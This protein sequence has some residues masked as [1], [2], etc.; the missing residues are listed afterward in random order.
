MLRS[1]RPRRDSADARPPEPAASESSRAESS[2]PPKPH[3][4]GATARRYL[5]FVARAAEGSP[6]SF[7][8]SLFLFLGGMIFIIYYAHEGYLPELDFG[9]ATSLLIAAALT[10]CLYVVVITA[11]LMMPALFWLLYVRQNGYF[12]VLWDDGADPSRQSAKW[13]VMAFVPPHLGL[14]YFTYS[15]L[16]DLWF[17]P[18]I[19]ALIA[20]WSLAV[21]CFRVRR[22][23]AR[24]PG[25]LKTFA[26]MS[27]GSFCWLGF[28]FAW[29]FALRVGVTQWAEIG[30][31]FATLLT[32]GLL[33]I[34]GSLNVVAIIVPE[35]TSPFLWVGGIAAVIL[36]VTVL[37]FDLSSNMSAFV[38]RKYGWGNI[39]SA[40]LVL[41][42]EG[43]STTEYLGLKPIRLNGDGACRLDG[44]RIVSRLGANYYLEAETPKSRKFKF[45]LP[46]AN[47]VAYEPSA[48][49]STLP[50]PTPSPSPAGGRATPTP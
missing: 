40:S 17:A 38:M 16:R 48:E 33:I 9:G 32:L 5:G 23:G 6:V 25:I 37:N 44:V 49:P 47:V 19:T 2:P 8:W 13:F 36:A 1:L 15:A 24:S 28:I 3:G 14:L 31:V 45:T 39:P 22:W 29:L 4:A 12:R 20:A 26:L 50:T 35:G 7:A 34:L 46:G 21:W 42:K 27:L 43:C 41:T 30:P 10:G 11:V 18:V